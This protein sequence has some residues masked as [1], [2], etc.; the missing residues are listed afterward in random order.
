MKSKERFSVYIDQKFWGNFTS[1]KNKADFQKEMQEQ[2][3]HLH[4]INMSDEG[5]IEYRKRYEN[6]IV[7]V[8]PI[9]EKA[10]HLN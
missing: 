6:S 5:A 10:L 3:K 8:Y 4:P 1:T 9:G 7:H 2:L